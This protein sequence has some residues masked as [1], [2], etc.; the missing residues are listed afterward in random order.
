[1]DDGHSKQFLLQHGLAEAKHDPPE[2]LFDLV[3]DPC[4]RNN[5]AQSPDHAAIREEL[6]GR[7]AGWMHDTADPLLAGYVPKPQGARV[8]L[9]WA[10]HPNEQEF[11]A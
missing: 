7:L 3:F 5:L 9:K 6:A 2:M 1:M 11:E 8:N 4:E 10:L